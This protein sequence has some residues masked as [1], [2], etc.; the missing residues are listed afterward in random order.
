[1]FRERRFHEEKEMR[2]PQVVQSRLVLRLACTAVTFLGLSSLAPQAKAAVIAS[3]SFNYS[4]G[5]ALA[6]ASGGSGWGNAWALSTGAATAWPNAVNTTN[7]APGI[8]ATN[9]PYST[10]GGTGDAGGA[11]QFAMAVASTSSGAAFRSFST[12]ISSTGGSTFWGTV[13]VKAPT[14]IKFQNF[15]QL[16]MNDTPNG[17]ASALADPFGT[18]NGSL[19][20]VP[21]VAWGG[22]PVNVNNSGSG[23]PIYSADA[24]FSAGT[25]LVTT[26]DAAQ[27]MFVFKIETNATDPSNSALA[28]KVST[29][30]ES[31]NG[32][33]TSATFLSTPL[34]ATPS[35][36]L[37]YDLPAA[38]QNSTAI[39]GVRIQGATQASTTSGRNFLVDEIKFG[40]TAS[41]VGVI[42]PVAPEPAT[43]GL[44]GVAGLAL[45][46]RRK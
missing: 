3:E 45:L 18:A 23:A 20:A 35:S 17:N 40:D 36:V 9:L 5:T 6:G 41:D 27:H 12:P 28:L 39:Q 10:F 14:S 4:S 24:D 26:G 7:G 46:R 37:Y 34:S 2:S 43:L 31:S 11:A 25:G 1:M 22:A 8:S 42:A 32:A 33:G 19:H 38:E 21:L 29:W 15:F 44:M 13:E 16:L 30:F